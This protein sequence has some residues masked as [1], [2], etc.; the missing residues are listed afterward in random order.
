M[1]VRRSCHKTVLSTSASL[2][3]VFVLSWRNINRKTLIAEV[4][5]IAPCSKLD[6]VVFGVTVDWHHTLT[7]FIWIFSVTWRS[8]GYCWVVFFLVEVWN[9]HL[10]SVWV[11]NWIS[12]VS[13]LRSVSTQSLFLTNSKW[14]RNYLNRLFNSLIICSLW[15]IS[16]SWTNLVKPLISGIKRSVGCAE[17]SLVD[18]MVLKFKTLIRG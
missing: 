8:H 16:V 1:R 9:V 2:T 5:I 3:S 13:T 7:V 4:R 11:V 14:I 12:I 6:I 18:F 17:V 15:D 10:G